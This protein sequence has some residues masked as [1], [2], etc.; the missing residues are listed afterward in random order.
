ML[1]KQRNGE[2]Q[3]IDEREMTKFERK[4]KE[5]QNKIIRLE[6]GKIIDLK[7]T[8]Q[9]SHM[10]DPKRKIILSVNR[11]GKSQFQ[12]DREKEEELIRN[13]ETRKNF[14]EENEKQHVVKPRQKATKKKKTVR[15]YG[16]NGY[17]KTYFIQ[18]NKDPA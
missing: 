4:Q 17:G 18:E 8:N 9:V 10:N 15:N 11:T 16:S 1:L 12:V 5:D 6:K 7:E 13:Y 2:K 3:K 14:L